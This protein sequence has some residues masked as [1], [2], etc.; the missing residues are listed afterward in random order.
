MSQVADYLLYLK[1]M[2]SYFKLES[3]PDV[4]I[5]CELIGRCSIKTR[6]STK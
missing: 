2:Y 6:P 1:L 3:P 4:L 5:F